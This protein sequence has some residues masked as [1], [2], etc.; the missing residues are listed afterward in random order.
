VR[1]VAQVEPFAAMA[2]F[3]DDRVRANGNRQRL[4]RCIRRVGLGLARQYA[5]D[6][7]LERNRR[8]TAA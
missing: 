8:D 7:D 3:V 4:L 1:R 2:P 5:R 6:V